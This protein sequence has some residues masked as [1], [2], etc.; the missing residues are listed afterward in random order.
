[1]QTAL[2]RDWLITTSEQI[3]PVLWTRAKEFSFELNLEPVKGLK[4]LL[5]SNLTDSR[6][7]QLQFMYTGMPTVYSGNYMRT[8][9]AIPTAMR[10]FKAEDGY[11]SD[12]FDQFLANIPVVARRVQDQYSGT[13]YPSTGFMEGNV[14]AGSP[15]NPEVGGVSQTSSDVLIPA[16]IAAYTGTSASK[17]TLDHFPD[18]LQCVPTGESLT[19]ALSIWAT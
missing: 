7:E 16:F 2:D 18:Y 11:H 9:W 8:A 14:L 1:M 12:A 10:N 4:I 5:T 3:S 15:F 17:V 6:T 19:M 13:T